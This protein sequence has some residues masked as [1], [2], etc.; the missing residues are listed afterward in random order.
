M[1]TFGGIGRI[2]EKAASRQPSGIPSTFS[3]SR[4]SGILPRK[5]NIL[6]GEKYLIFEKKTLKL[7]K[8][9]LTVHRNLS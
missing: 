8:R 2:C 3:A 1:P 7:S 6:S 9:F 4:H 5:W